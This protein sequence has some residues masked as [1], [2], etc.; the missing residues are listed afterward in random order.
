MN[1]NFIVK[2][3][4]NNYLIGSFDAFIET[5]KELIKDNSNITDEEVEV[6]LK[7]MPTTYRAAITNKEGTYIGY[8][9][10]YNVDAKNKTTSIR[11][12]VNQELENKDEILN[13]NN[14]DEIRQ[15]IGMVFQAFELFPHLTV[16]ENLILAPVH[17]KKMSNE[18][19]I[20]KVN[21]STELNYEMLKLD[22]KTYLTDL[23]YQVLF[24]RIEAKLKHSEISE[25][26][27]IS[28]DKSKKT[29]QV[30]ISKAKEILK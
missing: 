29:Y 12:E 4:T 8:I 15:H 24:L 13:E 23:E 6:V 16:L 2:L 25:V 30:A 7:S 3:Q 22:L 18:E 21:K 19:A 11:F 27:N 17:L 10:L 14:I 20:N 9:G 1:E 26:L 5:S 28:I